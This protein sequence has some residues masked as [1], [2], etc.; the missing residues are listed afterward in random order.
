MTRSL[1]L[2]ALLLL[3]TT[4]RAQDARIDLPCDPWSHSAG[5]TTA[6]VTSAGATDDPRDEPPP[7]FFGEEI[8]V[9]DGALVYVIDC[10]GSML[11]RERTTPGGQRDGPSRMQR[12]QAELTR[13]IAGL[14]RTL[15]FNVVAYSCAMAVLWPEA[16]RAT[17]ENKAAAL[18]FVAGMTPDG[19]TGTGPAS[20][21]ALSDRSAKALVLLTDGAPNCGAN[22]H[23]GHRAMIARA[24]AQRAAIN[25]FGIDA[26]GDHRVFCVNVASDSGGTYV[27][28]P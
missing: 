3:A 11:H 13:S 6:P 26:S 21:L 19:L 10:S 7:V 2:L 20:A 28:V 12:A 5:V 18:A 1:L 25:V 24:N 23:E 4:G 8:E 9:D 17:E 16:L 14:P 22:G 15:R 27:D